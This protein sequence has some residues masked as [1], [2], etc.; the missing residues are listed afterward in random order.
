MAK[1]CDK[2]KSINVECLVELKETRP[3][4]PIILD[5]CGECKEDFLAWIKVKPE[6]RKKNELY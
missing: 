3:I 6:G 5:L 4:T 2:C 1:I